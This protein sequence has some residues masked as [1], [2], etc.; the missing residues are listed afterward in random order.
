MPRH[1]EVLGK[2]RHLKGWRP[3]PP[4]LR[5]ARHALKAPMLATFRLP[6]VY[7]PR[8]TAPGT[9]PRVEDQA[10]IGSCVGHSV[11]SACEMRLRTLDTIDPTKRRFSGELS[12]L[13]TYYASRVWVEG[14]DP[15]DD[16]GTFIRSA[17]KSAR[18]YGVPLERFWPYDTS[19]YAEEPHKAAR[20]DG[21]KRQVLSYH[22]LTSIS[23][24][25]Y[26]LAK[27][28]PVV[29]GFTVPESISSAETMKTGIVKLFEPGE[30]NVGGHAVL[31]VGFDRPKK[32]F[33]FQ[34]S[35]SDGWGDKGYGYLPFLYFKQ[36]LLA[37]LW[38]LEV[39]ETGS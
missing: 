17:M 39:L 8:K 5:D 4:D 22:A 2:R 13:F 11:S 1:L 15:A 16:S 30:G 3:S 9:L 26:A 36:G 38:T 25:L 20:E 37:D 21:L 35:W 23:D 32:R 6:A 19:R 33:I 10:E 31:F 29:G 27:G 7:D 14:G 34:N 28:L 18:Q 24:I 12:R